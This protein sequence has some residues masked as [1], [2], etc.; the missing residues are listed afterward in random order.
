MTNR[1]LTRLPT[2]CSA[3]EIS[4]I[5]D[6]DGGVIVENWIASDAVAQLNKEIDPWLNN[7]PGTHSGSAASD[8][9]LGKKTRRLQ[10]LVIK[11][12]TFTRLL[13]DERLLKFAEHTIG[14]ISPTLIMN[15]GEVIDISPGESAQPMHRDDDAWNFVPLDTPM[16][17]NAI[18]A[19][20]DITEP[21][22]ATRVVAGSHKWPKDRVPKPH[23]IVSAE[24]NA[25][26]ALFFRGDTLHCGG[27]NT[28][29]TQRR[30]LSLGI[31]CGWLRPV[32][33]SYMNVP[34][35]EAKKLPERARELLGYALYDASQV[36]GGYL[37]YYNMGDPRIDPRANPDA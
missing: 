35:Q 37:G 31:C 36:G 1:T 9:F 16:M 17:I 30:A 18:T 22:G 3:E 20:V 2:T 33:N 26:S 29:N 21:M 34:P 5:C 8:D 23:E 11:A 13:T 15:N 10:A 4:E 28:S 25:G 27:A 12:P 14:P 7:H 24:M 32:E 6:R 19:L